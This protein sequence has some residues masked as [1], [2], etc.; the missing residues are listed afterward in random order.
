MRVD[1][2][3]LELTDEHARCTFIGRDATGKPRRPLIELDAADLSRLVDIARDFRRRQR[4][5]AATHASRAQRITDAGVME[6]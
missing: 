4:S 5:R 6:D 1:Y 3:N 2:I